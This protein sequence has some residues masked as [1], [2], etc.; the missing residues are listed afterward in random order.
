MPKLSLIYQDPF[1]SLID[2]LRFTLRAPIIGWVEA[3]RG[4]RYERDVEVVLNAPPGREF[5]RAIRRSNILWLAKTMEGGA[6]PEA[7]F[8]MLF[9][10]VSQRLRYYADMYPALGEFIM[11]LGVIF[12]VFASISITNIGPVTIIIL[13]LIGFFAWFLMP[14]D[15]WLTLTL[16]DI[17]GIAASAALA[18]VFALL[19]GHPNLALAV[20]LL[21]YGFATIPGVVRDWRTASSLGLRVLTSFNEILTKPIPTELLDLTPIETGLKPLWLDARGIGAPR[22]VSWANTMVSLYINTLDSVRRVRLIYSILLLGLGI[23]VT[24]VL[25]WFVLSIVSH[26]T[27][28]AISVATQYTGFALQAMP[29]QAYWATIGIGLAGGYALFDHRTSALLGGVLGLFAWFLLHP[30]FIL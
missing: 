4:T 7:Y 20:G 14:K 18:L 1:I 9:G 3:A 19:L 17:I 12:S 22:F 10:N 5:A 16:L 29:L 28:Q 6:S 2:D 8:Q 11:M 26:A 25:P 13:A 27:T 21:A 30:F 23:G 24:S 15:H